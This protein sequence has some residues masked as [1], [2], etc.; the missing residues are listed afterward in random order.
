[1]VLKAEESAKK[2][3]GKVRKGRGEEKKNVSSTFSN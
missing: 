2:E 1:M 3:A